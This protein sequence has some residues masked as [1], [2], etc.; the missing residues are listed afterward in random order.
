MDN[1]YIIEDLR[2]NYEEI[3][4]HNKRQ[5]DFRERY[6]IEDGI[7]SITKETYLLTVS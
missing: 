4:P 2:K 7:L 1:I 5:Y 6:S 3:N